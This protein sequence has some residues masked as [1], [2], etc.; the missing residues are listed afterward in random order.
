MTQ[1]TTSQRET[2][3]FQSE[4]KQ[5][6]SLMINSLYSNQE[7]FLRELISNAADAV[8]KLKFLALSNEALY[9]GDGELR[10]ELEFDESASTVTIRDNGIGMT[11][12]EVID[13]LGTIARSGTREFFGNLTGDAQKDSQLIG[14]F[15]VGFYSA[16]IVADKVSVL[17]RKAGTATGEG[18]RWDSDG[19]GE[20]TVETVERAP[21]GTEVTLHL[22]PAAKEFANRYRLQQIV[23]TYS[24]H[25]SVPIRML[26]E[27]EGDDAGQAAEWET[28]NHATALWTRNKKDVTDEEY[29]SFYLHVAHDFQEPMRW[30]HNH[31]EGKLE[32]TTLF[33][34]PARAPFDLWDRESKHGVK[35]YVQ[36]V[37]IM[38]DASQFL[39]R[40]L[41]FVR[42]VID[43]RDLPLNV[44][45]EI[46][47]HNKVVE[48]IRGASIKRVLTLIEQ[49]A[50]E[51]EEYAKFWQQFG[52]VLKEG[53]IEDNANQARVAGLLRFSSTREENADADVSLADYIARM[54]EGQEAIYY[55]TAENFTTAKNSPHLEQFRARGFEV[56]LLGEAVDE[57]VVSHLNEF[58]G[59][60]L[61]DVA[62][63]GIDFGDDAEAEKSEDERKCED[64]LTSRV[65]T[66]LG[67]KVKEVRISRRLTSSPACLVADEHD[68]S[69][70]LERILR[71]AGQQTSSTTR[72]L[73]LNPAHAIVK[74]LADETDDTRAGRWAELLYDQALLAEGSRLQDPA[75]FVKRMND[76]LSDLMH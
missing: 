76:V 9:E 58:E 35:L 11:R 50:K 21:H 53:V 70:N 29:K 45:R 16:F 17:T 34:I 3:G 32:Y 6:L 71:A 19:A 10:V 67:D 61:R 7:I 68:L 30:A 73:E 55:L 47:Q 33:Y 74:T 48:S 27:A 15:G 28:V 72:I 63:G 60:P 42:G 37:F 24:D 38:E 23:K 57:W 8:D 20:F 36:R 75:A 49:L 65:A 66:L 39:P 51:P 40:Y 22:K 64:S 4:I 52:A 69:P 13:N 2:M 5:L 43:T 26:K 54:P 12:D 56:L 41:R 18:V 44:S 62:R 46:L 25:I 1:T 31:V 14:Q 59:K